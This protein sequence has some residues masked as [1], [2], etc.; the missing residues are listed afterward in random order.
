MP[1]RVT[2][3]ANVWSSLP[4]VALFVERRSDVHER[5]AYAKLNS[6]TIDIQEVIRKPD[7]WL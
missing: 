2:I 5:K 3:V 7:T 4:G 6:Q 1:Y